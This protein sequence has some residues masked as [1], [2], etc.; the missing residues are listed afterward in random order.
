[1]N[2]FEEVEE[3]GA[4]A[5]P[6]RGRPESPFETME[7]M[8]F[9]AF[10]DVELVESVRDAERGLSTKGEREA[11]TQETGEIERFDGKA[12]NDIVAVGGDSASSEGTTD[13]TKQVS[14]GANLDIETEFEG[15]EDEAKESRDWSSDGKAELELNELCESRVTLDADEELQFVGVKVVACDVIVGAAVVVAVTL[16]VPLLAG[17]VVVE[18]GVIQVL[19]TEVVRVLG[20]VIRIVVGVVEEVPEVLVEREAAVEIMAI[21][22]VG[23]MLVSKTGGLIVKVVA[24]GS[25]VVKVGE[26]DS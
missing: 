18:A 1:M 4:G 22:C 13:I 21:V 8:R 25:D 14:S 10:C 16:T 9:L 15:Q 12:A 19:L 2:I 6:I 20:G 23:V 7:L 26:L 3:E 17:V 5:E 11:G 24:V